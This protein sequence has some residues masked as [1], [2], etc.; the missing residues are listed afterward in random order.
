MTADVQCIVIGAGVVGLAIARELAQAG[1]EVLVA[2]RGEGIGVGTSSRNSEVIHAGI[3]YPAG[4]LK[5]RLCVQGKHLLYDYCKTKGVGH[6]Q[7]GKLLVATNEQEASTLDGIIAK[8]RANGVNDLQRLSRSQAQALEPALHCTAA[9]LSPST[10]IVDSHHLMLAYQGDAEAAGA[11]F[12]FHCPFEQAKV[13][14]TDPDDALFEVSFGGQEPTTL[15]CNLLI[16]AAGLGAVDVAHRIE[17]LPKQTIATA[18]LCKGS[19]FSLQG[20]SPFSRLIYPVPQAAGLGVHIT[21][22]LAGQAKFG[23][24]TEWIEKE[25][26]EVDIARSESFY[27]AVRS[28]WPDLKDGALQPGYAGIR[29]KISGPDQASADFRI[30]ASNEH[31]VPGLIN[32]YGIESPGLTSSLAIGAHVRQVLGL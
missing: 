20:K 29:P 23:P 32:L 2:E 16:N 17:G 6:R 28:Y 8:A 15:T 10:G 9:V 1:L 7:L 3:Y 30:S 5:A 11:Q 24:D 31:G 12:V 21:L 13:L 22:D 14:R 27:E 4:S 25:D 19:Y 26:Y 18:Y